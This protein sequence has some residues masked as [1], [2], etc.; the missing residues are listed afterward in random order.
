MEERTTVL[1][2]WYNNSGTPAIFTQTSQTTG[3]ICSF[4]QNGSAAEIIIPNYSAT[5][6]SY[7]FAQALA[8][9]SG[10]NIGPNMGTLSW[11]S[12]AAITQIDVTNQAGN[13]FITGSTFSLY[14]MP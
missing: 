1:V 7:K 3:I 12:S 11:A 6:L 13:N 5:T 2:F 10:A 4:S 9:N 14:G 8:S